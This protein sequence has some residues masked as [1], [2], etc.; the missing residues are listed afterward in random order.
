[1]R[2]EQHS[3]KNRLRLL[4]V[5]DKTRFIHLKQFT[6]E[7]EK[8]GIESKLIYDIEFIDKF[9][10]M[11][12]KKKIEK[13]K[14]FKKILKEFDPNAVLL[15]RISKIGKK[16]IEQNIP[17]LILLR[18]NYWEE[19]SWAKKTIYKSRIKRLA[20]TKNEEL[21]DLCLRKS[22]IIL[23][24]SKYLENEVK[25]RYPEKNIELFPA[26]GRDP[27]EWNRI[28]GMNLKHPCVG[29]LQG[30]NVWGKTRE[31]LTLTKVMKE[32]PDVTFYFAGDGFYKDKIIP[33]LK[34]FR[35]FVWLGSLEYPVEVKKFLSEIDVYLLLSGM[36]GLGQTIIEALLMEKPVIATN[37]GGIP[38]LIEDGKTGFLIEI[39]DHEDLIKKINRECDQPVT[40]SNMGSKGKEIMQEHF[41]WDS[42]AKK[43][44]LILNQNL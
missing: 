23:P 13:D 27:S 26:D 15:D 41:A 6:I 1:M 18:G 37:I 24:I 12:I 17:L 43:F 42:I 10:Q 34:N 19:S 2:K 21:F 8:I 14:N 3:M 39:G 31:L 11:N 36:E 40:A 20:A 28:P 22:S 7:L 5:G 9:F 4:I 32:L 33:K 38:E 25:K 29:L 44:M 16:V 35:N 30:M